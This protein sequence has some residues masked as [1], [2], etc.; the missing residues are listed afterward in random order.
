MAGA[1]AK[2]AFPYIDIMEAS[3]LSRMCEGVYEVLD[4]TG[5]VVKGGKMRRC[6]QDY[7]C[8]VDEGLERV[9]FDRSV[10]D[11]AMGD[12][13]KGFEIQ[14]REEE[15][16]VL[17]K[18]GET[19]QFINACGT[20]YFHLD[21][22]DVKPPTRKEFYDYLRLLD[23]LPHI[24]FQNCFPFFGFAKV[25]ECMKLLESVAAKYRVS[26]KAQ[27]E[28]TVF[29]N[30]QFSTEMAKAMNTDLC[31][32]VNSAAPLTYFPETAEQIFNY[33]EAGL[34]FHFAAGPTRGL[35][36]P[37]SAA[38]SVISNNTEA[39][40]GIV[41]AQA[42][43]PGSRVWV[44]SMIMTP[45]MATGKPAFGNIGNSFTDM[46]FNQYWRHYRIPS[47]SNAASWTSSK[48]ID[49][50]AGYE[51]SMALLTQVLSGATVISYQ[52]GMYAE[53]YASPVKAVIDDDI[54]GMT[55]RLLKG[56]DVSDEGMAV[57]LIKEIGPMPGSFMETD[58]T[59]EN[60]RNECY[61]PTVASMESYQ[62]WA[63]WGKKTIIEKAHGRME[64][65]LEQHVVPALPK[66]KEQ[67]LED[68]LQD[69]RDYYRKKGLISDEE[70][71]IYQEDLY[72]PNYPYA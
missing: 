2:S 43:K 33:A 55:K 51:Q 38:G 23:G 36:S 48:I 1:G 21:S 64:M 58:E 31:Q 11:R 20:K 62:E 19:T 3:A 49:Y 63:A 30:Y 72:S 28:G 14:A 53:L 61:V 6:L 59:L 37:M 52:G 32:I 70:W 71:R 7:G 47:W 4:H 24:D 26:T 9:Y 56:I 45:D 5:V 22:Q 69:A 13:P 46:A 18:P 60:W 27:I 16:N 8:R 15:N 66:A 41:M 68:I 29:D 50:Q 40:A 10:I 17:L 25:P 57:D 42:V 12:T 44:N 67:A 39:L 54:V 34:P 35:T 65:L